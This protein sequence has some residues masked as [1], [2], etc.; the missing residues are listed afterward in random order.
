MMVMTVIWKLDTRIRLNL[1]RSSA[2]CVVE[3]LAAVRSTFT[4]RNVERNGALRMTNCLHISDVLNQRSVT[5]CSLVVS[6]YFTVLYVRY[7]L[8]VV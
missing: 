4:S 1:G 5:W 8:P 7:L 2:I 6:H 3:S